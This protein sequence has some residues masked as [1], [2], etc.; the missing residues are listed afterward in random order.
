MILQKQRPDSRSQKERVLASFMI[1]NLLSC[2][3][4]GYPLTM[5]KKLFGDYDDFIN[6]DMTK[7]IKEVLFFSL[8]RPT[9]DSKGGA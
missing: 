1:K 3:C 4:E 9:V 2:P 5:N 8:T 6:T 7:K